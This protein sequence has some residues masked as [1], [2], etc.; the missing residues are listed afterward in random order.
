MVEG[1]TDGC[2]YLWVCERVAVMSQLR[3][4]DFGLLGR[5]GLDTVFGG[6][7]STRYW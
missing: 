3:G 5:S 2:G 6:E 1:M 7:T 4:S